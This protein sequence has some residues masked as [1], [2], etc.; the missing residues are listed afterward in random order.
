[1]NVRNYYLWSILCLLICTLQSCQTEELYVKEKGLGQK[2]GITTEY[3]KGAEA[4]RI[5]NVL[6]TKC[7]NL[8]GNSQQLSWLRSDYD[9]IDYNSILLV[10]DSLGVRNYIFKVTNHPEDDYKT[11]HNLVMTDKEGELELTLMKYAMTDIFAEEYQAELKKF[12]EFR[13][14]ITSKKLATTDPCQDVVIDYTDPVI[15]EPNDGPAQGSGGYDPGESGGTGESG[16]TGGGF[17]ESNDSNCT[18]LKL[19]V[20]CQCGRMYSS[21]D[22][23][24]ASMCGDGSNPG[25][26][27]SLVLSYINTCRIGTI[28]C[29]PD[30]TLGVLEKEKPCKGDPLKNPRIC[31]SSPT[32]PVGGAFGCTRRD[33]NRTC[34]G[35]VG[36]KKHA[37]LDLKANVNDNV[38]C[39]YSGTVISLRSNMGATE[40]KANSLGNFIEIESIIN[41]QTVRIK[42]CHLGNVNVQIGSTITQ[43]SLIGSIGRSGNA[44]A[45]GV[46]THLHLQAKVMNGDSF[47]ITNPINYLK[48][49]FDETT[50]TPISNC[51]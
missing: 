44:G 35:Y 20:L 12:Y 16:N 49:Q 48:T 1:M 38:F 45:K 4:K 23:Y 22:S 25:Y 41:G 11:F 7:N 6:K 2:S 43:G 36:K 19:E 5:A 51:N 50:F 10:V 47:E 14:T 3:L 34:D 15:S 13:G 31:P 17:G 33:P 32:N 39:M 21:W 24:S 28:N 9:E 27:V 8:G 42:Y 40:Y 30:G 46:N 37:G 18:E 26:S 29:T